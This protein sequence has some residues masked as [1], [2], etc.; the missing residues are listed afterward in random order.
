M[1][2]PRISTLSH[3][4][5][6]VAA[7]IH[8]VLRPAYAQEAALLNGGP[9]FPP[10]ARTVADVQASADTHLGAWV[11]DE[12]A[13]VLSVGDDDEPGQRCI[14]MLVVH[15]RHQRQGIARAL[16]QAQLQ[17]EAMHAHAVS[18]GARNAPALA[19]YTGLGFTVY[20]TGALGGLPMVK[21]RR[22]ASQPATLDHAGIAA[23]VP[24]A[25]T[26][27]LLDR[28]LDWCPE[29]IHCSAR[30]HADPAN[31]L[32]TASGLLAPVAIEYASQAMALHGTLSAAPGSPPT[33]GFLAAVRGVRL[34]VPR[35]DT[36]P[37]ALRIHAARQ[38]GDAR[39]ALYA[40]SLNDE[41][42]HLLVQGRATV[43]LDA[44][45]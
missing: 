13:G 34:A 8:A 29:H 21:L 37:G 5:A 7:Q 35:L 42:G 45:P 10:L 27:C 20:R 6:A 4:D 14:G 22:P 24:H 38:A 12:L 31:P 2:P 15:P 19:L 36:V 18:T 43:I 26:M 16:M 40:F 11:G 17:R 39:Q 25:G 1:T 41:A 33:P 32:R 30:S 3:A 44:L 28:L 9:D 23:R